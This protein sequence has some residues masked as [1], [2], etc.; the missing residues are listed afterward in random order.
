MYIA[1]QKLGFDRAYR[2]HKRLHLSE[3][4]MIREYNGG[5]KRERIHYK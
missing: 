3:E 5:E 4:N 1:P 2:T